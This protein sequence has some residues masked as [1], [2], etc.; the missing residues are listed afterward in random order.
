MIVAFHKNQVT[1]FKILPKNTNFKHHIYLD[2]WKKIVPYV[3]I[4]R[5]RRS[6][7][8]HDNA[9]PH[10]H[11]NIKSFFTSHQWELETPPYSPDLNP[12]DYDGIMRIKRP[13]KG[14]LFDHEIDRRAVNEQ[15]IKEINEKKC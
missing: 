15:F 3:Q 1:G 9:R 13:L 8:L 11:H 2:F 4:C 12:C 6:L 10:K 7:V 14:N 5:I